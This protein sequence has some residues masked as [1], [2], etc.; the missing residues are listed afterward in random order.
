MDAQIREELEKIRQSAGGV[1]RAKDIVEFAKNKKTALHQRFPWDVEKAAYQHWLEIARDIIVQ[2]KVTVEGKDNAEMSV[3]LYQSLDSDRATKDGGYRSVHDIMSDK[4]FTRE[5]LDTALAELGVF[6]R[7][8]SGLRELADVMT[9]IKK[10][11]GRK[12]STTK[13]PRRR[14]SG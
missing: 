8:Y 4:Q 1:L 2:V 12:S 5:L 11:R 10:V 9:A 6:E 14:R 3:R 13:K 7:R